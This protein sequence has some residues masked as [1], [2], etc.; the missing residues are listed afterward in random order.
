LVL[1]EAFDHYVAWLG[2]E[3]DRLM[4]CLGASDDTTNIYLGQGPN[5]CDNLRGWT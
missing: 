2:I 1:T 3:V 4:I 5:D